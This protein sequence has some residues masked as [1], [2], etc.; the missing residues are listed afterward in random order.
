VGY[1]VGFAAP[2]TVTA[3]VTMADSASASGKKQSTDEKRMRGGCHERFTMSALK[4]CGK[5][6]CEFYCSKE[7]QKK[8]WLTHKRTCKRNCEWMH[9]GY[10]RAVPHTAFFWFFLF[11]F[12]SC[13]F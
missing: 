8:D 13:C 3:S 2:R 10:V 11:G 5:C 4:R 12:F 9:R 1:H 7:C 6:K